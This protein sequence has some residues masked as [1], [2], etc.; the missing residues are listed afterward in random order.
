MH[1][2]YKKEKFIPYWNSKLTMELTEY[3][4]GDSKGMMIVNLSSEE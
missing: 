4:T 1:S 3:L 2:L